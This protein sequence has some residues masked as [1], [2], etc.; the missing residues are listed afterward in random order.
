MKN[1]QKNNSKS[2]K[3]TVVKFRRWL[4]NLIYPYQKLE[5]K[6]EPDYQKMVEGMDAY[7]KL[8]HALLAHPDRHVRRSTAKYVKKNVLNLPN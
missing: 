7:R 8:F 2:L 1:S 6:N 3:N 5:L 4:G